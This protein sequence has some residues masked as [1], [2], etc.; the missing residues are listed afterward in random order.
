MD[1]QHDTCEGSS[2]LPSALLKI[3]ILSHNCS[4]P[5]ILYYI[6]FMSGEDTNSQDRFPAIQ[7]GCSSGSDTADTC[8]GLP[9]VKEGSSRDPVAMEKTWARSASYRFETW[10]SRVSGQQSE[11]IVCTVHVINPCVLK[12]DVMRVNP[13]WR[14][15][16]FQENKSP[17]CYT[18]CIDPK[19]TCGWLIDVSWTVG[20]SQPQQHGRLHDDW[21]IPGW[22]DP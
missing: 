16:F 7:G 10:H 4:A 21:T 1:G 19:S 14:L 15:N 8:F 6:V 12:L 18:T 2:C 3:V 11:H 9:C 5:N 17:G 20:T 22:I 13:V